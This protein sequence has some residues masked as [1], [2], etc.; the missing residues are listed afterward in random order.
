MFFLELLCL[1][2]LV[3]IFKKLIAVEK[4]IAVINENFK[5]LYCDVSDKG[6]NRIKPSFFNYKN[7]C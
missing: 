6:V 1:V 3:F 7:I 2:V 5:S 4:N